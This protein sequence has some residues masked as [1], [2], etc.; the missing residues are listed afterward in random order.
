MED[1]TSLLFDLPGFRVVEVRRVA[2]GREAV[3]ERVAGEE[4]CPGCGTLTS[5]IHDR[6]V[7][8]L[9]D[10]PFGEGPLRLVWRKRRYRCREAACPRRSF[11]EATDV[12]PPRSRLTGRLRRRLVT[13]IAGSNRSVSD[14]AREYGVSWTTAHRALIAAAGRLLPAPAPT[15]VLGIDETRATSLRWVFAEAGWRLSN[16]WLTSFVDLHGDGGIIGLAPGRSGGCVRNWLAEQPQ[17]FRNAVEVVAID[18]SAP[19]ASGLRRALPDARIVVDHWHLVRLANQMVT[20]VR[21]R[22]TRERHGGRGRKIDPAW[23][24]RRLL[25]RAGDTLGPSSLTRLKAMLATDD[26]TNEIGAAWG[27]KELLRQLL[28]AEPGHDARRRLAAF[29]QAVL[30][31]DM[32]ETT[33][34]AETIDAWWPQIL[35]FLQ[36]RITNARTEG[37]NRII[38]QVKRVG[39]GFRNIDNY[40]RRIMLVTAARKAA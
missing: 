8:V 16:P 15:P 2:G 35:A 10:V 13:S 23:S 38:K 26:P 1:A 29:Y 4:G 36:L 12:V 28:A 25:L 30:R 32:P 39:C 6:P 21:Q 3:V 9:R 18:P 20:E 5:R 37:Y 7:S 24:H 34:L 27:V 11:T 14:V 22:V 40:Q 17:R 31:A 33:R 19:Y